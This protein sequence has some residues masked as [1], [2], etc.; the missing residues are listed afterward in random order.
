MRTIKFRGK[1][2]K[3]GKWVYGYL[4]AKCQ[5]TTSLNSEE[6]NAVHLVNPETIGQFTGLQDN[7]G[8]DIYEGDLISFQDDPYKSVKWDKNYSCWIYWH[9]D[10]EIFGEDEYFDWLMLK[11]QDQRHY[12]N[13]GNIY[14]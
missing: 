13:H 10:E 5:I 4:S 14:K 2:I 6:G 7:E 1:R 3:D 8:N 11:K 9:S 12:V